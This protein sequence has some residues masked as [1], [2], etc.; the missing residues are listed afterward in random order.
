MQLTL[1]LLFLPAFL[2]IKFLVSFDPGTK[3]SPKNLWQAA[4]FG[5]VALIGVLISGIILE[6]SGRNTSITELALVG[7][8]GAIPTFFTLLFHAGIEEVAKFVPLAIFVYKK[9]FFNEATDGIIYFA[10]CGLVFAVI[11]TLLYALSSDSPAIG[12]IIFR[13]SMGLFL[14]PAATALVG[15][16]LAMHRVGKIKSFSFVLL[17]LAI[18]TLLHAFYNFGLVMSSSTGNLAW[19][20]F[21]VFISLSMSASIFIIFLKA[22]MFD[23]RPA[24]AV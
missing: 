20:A 2:L 9:P 21:S 6:L 19:A 22:Y 12:T 5:A 10:V 14:H 23:T 7:S 18:V 1:F 13:H 15:V 8:N 17:M 16:T 24:R 3:E 4:G 11:E